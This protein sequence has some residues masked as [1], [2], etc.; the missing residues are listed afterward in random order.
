MTV[1]ANAN[2]SVGERVVRGAIAAG[3]SPEHEGAGWFLR[4]MLSNGEPLKGVVSDLCITDGV[5]RLEPDTGDG[6]DI[7]IN[8]EDISTAWVEF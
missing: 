5:L 6:S 4:L 8:L 7:Y 2:M 1:T 3:N